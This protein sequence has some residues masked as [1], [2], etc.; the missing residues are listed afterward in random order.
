MPSGT[1]SHSASRSAPFEPH[2]ITATASTTLFIT[3]LV[4]AG[5]GERALDVC[6]GGRVEPRVLRRARDLLGA[7]EQRHGV[8][9]TVRHK[10]DVREPEQRAHLGDVVSA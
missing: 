8:A 2:D 10:H 4:Y 5:A 3:R 6:A 9:R 7:L 1:M